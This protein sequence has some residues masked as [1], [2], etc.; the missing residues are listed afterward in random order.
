MNSIAIAA[1]QSSEDSPSNS[2]DTI[3]IEL[4]VNVWKI[5]GIRDIKFYFDFGIKCDFKYD[6]LKIFL[7]F[8]IELTEEKIG[9]NQKF[10]PFFEDYGHII[11]DDNTL[12][13]ALFNE[14]M[15]ASKAI[16]ECFYPVTLANTDPDAQPA[17]YIYKLGA[18]NI[19]FE[20]DTIPK[21]TF[22]NINIENVKDLKG[23]YYI[24]F[25]VASRINSQ[26]TKKENLTNDL[27]QAAFSKMNFY[28]LRINEAR[29]LNDK[30]GEEIKK[31]KFS[32]V[33]FTKAHV[34][35]LAKYKT[36]VENGS[37]AKL[38]TRI[39]EPKVWQKYEPREVSGELFLAHHWKFQDHNGQTAGNHGSSQQPTENDNS[40]KDNEK[41]V[42]SP[43]KS[44][45]LFFTATYPRIQ[46]F[47]ILDYILLA[48]LL[49]ALGSY[50]VDFYL[51][52]NNTAVTDIIEWKIGLILGFAGYLTLRL[53][54]KYVVI[55]IYKS[56]LRS[57]NDRQYNP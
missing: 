5:D 4:H 12:L 56:V 35:Y 13:S 29:T 48:I 1:K 47:T 45:N 44:I 8:E 25:R 10:I 14:N 7:P 24:R 20:T 49:S 36:T 43:V 26:I 21:G 52:S 3:G 19:T 51:P 33:T 31:H 28:D 39:I 23:D 50:L 27:L 32:L 22:L 55:P 54:W 30:A 16:D 42:S 40:K 34:F 15:T 57:I 17:F 9:E 2:Q 53:V 41:P 18:N 46:L 6:R 11:G 38:D 37:D